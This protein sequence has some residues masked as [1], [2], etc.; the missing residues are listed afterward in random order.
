MKKIFCWKIWIPATALLIAAFSFYKRSS[1]DMEA[2]FPVKSLLPAYSAGEPEKIILSWKDTRTTLLFTETKEWR[3]RER[4]NHL[5]DT[6][7]VAEFLESIRKLRPLRRAVPDDRAT[8]SRLRVNPEESEPEKIPGLRV[9]IYGKKGIL[10]DLTFGI[11]YYQNP[12]DRGK[13]D[14]M[15][16]GRWA[17]VVLEDGQKVIPFLSSSVLE[18][19]HPVPGRWID[20]PVFENPGQLVRIH[21]SANSG[22]WMIARLSP[23]EHFSAV[24]PSEKSMVSQQKLS[25]LLSLLSKR[26]PFEV[27]RED[28]AGELV[29]IGS[30]LTVDKSGMNRK[31]TFF[32]TEKYPETVCCRVSGEYKGSDPAVRKSLERFLK[33]RAGWL[34]VIPE[35]LYETIKTNPAGV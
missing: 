28:S 9:R 18:E 29:Q 25:V 15:P 4:E 7:T 14:V 23:A 10:R 19:Y 20:F 33:E 26:Y 30:L 6:A 8:C 34:Y 12:A 16:D 3:I 17:G 1:A 11:G 35:K 24:I 21:F 31:L 27:V 5:A 22:E 32:T 2:G 13:K